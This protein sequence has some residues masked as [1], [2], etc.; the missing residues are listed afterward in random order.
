M[1]DMSYITLL[2]ERRARKQEKP[3]S[4]WICPVTTAY[5][6]R[7]VR[8]YM[9]LPAVMHGEV[10]DLASRY[11]MSVVQV[12]VLRHFCTGLSDSAAAKRLR[13]VAAYTSA[14]AYVRG[15]RQYRRHQRA[16]VK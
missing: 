1:L 6:V 7:R 4:G 5:S 13:S 3:V 16:A 14:N 2:I 8:E 12:H 11:G 15:R 10:D 9:L